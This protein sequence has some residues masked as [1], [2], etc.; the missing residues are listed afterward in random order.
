MSYQLDR[1]STAEAVPVMPSRSRYAGQPINLTSRRS[2]EVRSSSADESPIVETDTHVTVD[3]FY[4][5]GKF[6]TAT[7]PLD[8]VNVVSGQM[9]NFSKARTRRTSAGVEVLRDKDG[10]PK[11]RMPFLNHVQSRFR[12]S[13]DDSV[14][15]YPLGTRK[16]DEPAH[17]IHDFVCSFEAAGPAG[18]KFNVRDAL[19][20]H[21]VSAHRFLSTQ[22]MVFER[23]VV[24]GK[25]LTESAPL[26]LDDQQRRAVL[27][28]SLRKS[29]HAG[30]MQPYYL[31]RPF[32]TNN[33]TS[34]PF[35]I[36]DQIVTYSRMQRIGA[37]LYR[38][39]LN[40]RLYLRL[41][42]LDADPNHRG[43]VHEEFDEYIQHPETQERKREHVRRRAVE[44]EDR[45]QA[46]REDESTGE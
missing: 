41:R 18:V 10:L 15:L 13:D 46:Q 45:R 5:E 8:V 42:G 35:H 21:L 2:I 29:H 14:C 34:T 25:I 31:L 12:L 27:V 37:L 33:C 19:A 3:R 20:G 39:P 16:F 23:I 9:F 32:G 22:E 11:R 24:E 36:L 44:R 26:P 6:W 40:P 28:E 7:I 1:S 4:H 38:L 17:R 30:M 43:V